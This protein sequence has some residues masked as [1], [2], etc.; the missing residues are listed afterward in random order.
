MWAVFSTFIILHFYDG[1]RSGA[2]IAFI[3]ISDH[4]FCFESS[5]LN[6][7]LDYLP[8]DTVFFFMVILISTMNNFDMTPPQ[9]PY[10]DIWREAETW[11]SISTSFKDLLYHFKY[12]LSEKYDCKP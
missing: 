1:F 2:I 3:Q 6:C 4:C 8:E 12:I 9:N 5:N 11:F 10:I 7:F